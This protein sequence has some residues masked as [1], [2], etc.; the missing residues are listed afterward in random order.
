M[1]IMDIPRARL[2]RRWQSFVDVD[3]KAAQLQLTLER[4]RKDDYPF[5]TF[6]WKEPTPFARLH[7]LGTARLHNT[8][9]TTSS[10]LP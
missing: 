9:D 2:L 7:S 5:S 8:E 10:I 1:Q 6:V 4:L 3:S